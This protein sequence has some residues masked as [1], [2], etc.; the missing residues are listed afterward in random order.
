MQL[1]YKRI[2][3]EEEEEKEEEE[4]ARFYGAPLWG[5]EAHEKEFRKIHEGGRRGRGKMAV[6]SEMKRERERD[7]ACIDLSSHLRP[8]LIR[9]PF[10][11]LDQRESYANLPL[12]LLCGSE[13]EEFEAAT[14]SMSFDRSPRAKGICL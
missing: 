3:L 4:E 14:V 7:E 12:A 6:A 13:L 5:G 11:I 8:P 9:C 1:S 2:S 10:R